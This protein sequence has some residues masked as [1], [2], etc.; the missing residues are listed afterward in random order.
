M[1][2][3]WLLWSFLAYEG[4]LKQCCAGN[5]G[6]EVTETPVTPDDT[7]PVKRFPIDFQYGNAAAFTNDGFA[8]LKA[9]LVSEM[10]D[11]NILEVTG[12]YFE[13]EPK[14]DGYD[15]MGFARAD[16]IRQLLVPDIPADRIH[17]RARL[18]D[19]TEGGK[20]GYFEASDYSWVTPEEVP[21]KT[22]EE[23]ADRVIIRFPYNSAIKDKD[24]N[25]DEYLNKLADR[26]KQTGEKVSLTGHTDNTGQPEGNL[27]LSERRAREV[28]AIL[29]K[30]GVKSDQIIVDAKGQTQPVDNND[31]E[32]GRHNNRRVEVRL[33]KT[34]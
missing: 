31:T 15:N 30:K 33:I 4:C 16:K 5:G 2:A 19:E 22:V 32:D 18:V 8:E 6:S 20:T 10:K 29:L 9:R 11:N 14:P 13:S 12:F 17:L 25:I 1:L 28:Q 34:N 21:A 23:L 27:K 7:G 26:I 3:I 24:A